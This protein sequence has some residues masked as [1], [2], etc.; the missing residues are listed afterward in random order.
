M[1]GEFD[2][3]HKYQHSTFMSWTQSPKPTLSKSKLH[4]KNTKNKRE[5]IPLFFNY[6][7]L[8]NIRR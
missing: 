7:F 2:V 1:H 4:E 5:T 3:V 8:I 6:L